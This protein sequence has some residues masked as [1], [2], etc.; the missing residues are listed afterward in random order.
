[1]SIKLKFLTLLFFADPPRAGAVHRP[2][3][4]HRPGGA[5]LGSQVRRR[6]SV[7]QAAGAPV[8]LIPAIKSGPGAQWRAAIG[9]R[10][11]LQESQNTRSVLPVGAEPT[12]QLK[13]SVGS[14][15]QRLP[16]KL[17]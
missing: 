11:S 10:Q 1:M 2:H 5:L 15:T 12:K 16:G 3:R 8:A 4:G 13:N 14:L 6:V 9:L 7:L 17:R